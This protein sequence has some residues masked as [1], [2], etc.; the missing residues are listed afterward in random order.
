MAEATVVSPSVLKGLITSEGLANCIRMANNGGWHIY[1]TK[2]CVSDTIGEIDATRTTLDMFETW[3]EA[4]ISGRIVQNSETIEFLCTIP[5]GVAATTKYI[6]EIYLLAET[7]DGAEFLLGICGI[8][9]TAAYDPA[10]SIKFRVII[11]IQNLNLMDLFVFKY[12]QAAEI[13]DHNNDP[14]AH[15]DLSAAIAGVGKPTVIFNN[16][17]ATEG[18]TLF[19]DTSSGPITIQLPRSG[20][21]AGSK[22][23]IIDVGWQCHIPGKEINIVSVDH[24]IDKRRA[25]LVLNQRGASVRLIYW[26][27]QKGWCLDIGGRFY[28]DLDHQVDEEAKA[29]Y[30]TEYLGKKDVVNMN[31]PGTLDSNIGD[32]IFI[33]T[34]D[35]LN[36]VANPPGY[37]IK[38][39]ANP[40]SGDKVTIIDSNGNFW[41]NPPKVD[42]NGHTIS[43]SNDYYVC[44][45]AYGLYD[46]YFDEFTQDWKVSISSTKSGTDGGL[47]GKRYEQV[48]WST[49]PAQTILTVPEYIVGTSFAVWLDGIL[50]KKGPGTDPTASYEEIG[51]TGEASTRFRFWDAIPPGMR[52][53]TLS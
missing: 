23:E 46:F 25:T 36:P 22:V 9:G 24:T 45:T 51:E 42:G 21:R 44:D 3:Y 27:N 37:G 38:L 14:N 35:P 47:R 8:D 30:Y 17:T 4:P 39:P 41:R 18:Q 20:L 43:G 48:F 6:R 40:V 2:F 1:P 15:P 34:G 28:A 50:C 16:Y 10:G 26:P 53:T 33:K 12:T 31:N 29:L 11:S 5:P 13:E 7:S 32:T 52:I 19:V 49:L